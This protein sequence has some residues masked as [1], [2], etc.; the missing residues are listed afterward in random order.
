MTT[1]SKRNG[2]GAAGGGG[3]GTVQISSRGAAVAMTRRCSEMRSKPRHAIA[4]VE[5]TSSVRHVIAAV[6]TSRA[7]SQLR[8][9]VRFCSWR[10]RSVTAQ[11]WS[12]ARS[13]SG[14]TPKKSGQV[15][16]R[17]SQRTSSWSAT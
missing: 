15:G 6:L 1:A 2:A 7:A 11:S 16:L 12:S 14:R 8:R 4:T 13:R 5:T 17:F 10:L 3:G 9:W